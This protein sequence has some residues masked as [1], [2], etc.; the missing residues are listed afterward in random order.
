MIRTTTPT[1]IFEFPEDVSGF[2]VYELTYMQGSRTMVKTT[3]E[4]TIKQYSISY[5]LTQED[6]AFFVA[7]TNNPAFV[8]L[9][10]LTA[11]GRDVLATKIFAISV[12]DALSDKELTLNED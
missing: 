10:V 12:S 7:G 6:A 8:Q 2:G 5:H 11:D 3:E 4:L 9:R 1:H